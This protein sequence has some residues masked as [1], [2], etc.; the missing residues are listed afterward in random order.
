MET[1]SRMFTPPGTDVRGGGA[2]P[3]PVSR[4]DKSIAEAERRQARRA[5]ARLGLGFG[6]TRLAV[7]PGGEPAGG[8]TSLVGHIGQT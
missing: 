1:F 4:Q 8:R 3:T 7:G 5:A 2:L 6:S